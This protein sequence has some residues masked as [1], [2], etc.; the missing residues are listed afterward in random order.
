MC[1][2]TY[3]RKRKEQSSKSMLLGFSF[4]LYSIHNMYLCWTT[5]ECGV[6]APN[7]MRTRLNTY[8]RAVEAVSGL[9][10]VIN[11][12]GCLCENACHTRQIMYVRLWFFERWENYIYICI[13]QSNWTL[14]RCSL[15]MYVEN[16]F[17][18]TKKQLSKDGESW[19]CWNRLVWNGIKIDAY[20]FAELCFLMN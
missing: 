18:Y 11:T 15:C 14:A 13:L 20:D 10:I 3:G 1:S 17:L 19:I 16:W 8:V 5:T 7:L 9:C 12:F 2:K 6:L 4:T